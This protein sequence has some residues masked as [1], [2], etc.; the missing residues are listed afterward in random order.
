[1]RRIV[2]VVKRFEHRETHVCAGFVFKLTRT[3][4]FCKQGFATRIGDF[5]KEKINYCIEWI[6]TQKKLKE[7]LKTRYTV[8]IWQYEY[9]EKIISIIDEHVI[10][11][12]LAEMLEELKGE[13]K[14]Q[15]E[16]IDKEIEY[17]VNKRRK[18]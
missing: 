5:A 17:L 10:K 13:K 15:E 1:M 8:D 6:N 12:K 11:L 18:L 7:V 9:Y 14:L 2:R 3:A 16:L 4:C